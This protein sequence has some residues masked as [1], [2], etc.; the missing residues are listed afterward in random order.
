[1]PAIYDEVAAAFAE[2]LKGGG[3]LNLSDTTLDV[4]PWWATW[5]MPRRSAEASAP[6]ASSA[7]GSR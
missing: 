5:S 7:S 2:F 1:M 4:R 6:R 3:R